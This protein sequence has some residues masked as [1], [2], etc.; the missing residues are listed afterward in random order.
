MAN[1]HVTS[2]KF[3]PNPVD[4]GSEKTGMRNGERENEKRRKMEMKKCGN[5][6]EVINSIYIHTCS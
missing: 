3:A 4:W 6:T 1:H 5:E 2:G